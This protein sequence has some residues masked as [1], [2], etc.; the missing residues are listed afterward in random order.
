MIKAVSN[1]FRGIAIATTAALACATAVAQDKKDEK[2]NSEQ[3]HE[4]KVLGRVYDAVTGKQI[5]SATIKAY[6]KNGFQQ[7]GKSSGTTNSAGTYEL[8]LIIGR[9]ST[10]TPDVGRLLFT[11]LGGF[12]TG[13]GTSKD[14]QIDVSKVA[15]VVTAKGYKTFEGSVESRSQNATAFRMEL[16]PVLLMPEGQTG[17]SISEPHFSPYRFIKPS[18]SSNV[19]VKGQTLIFQT[20]VPLL[21]AKTSQE[22][23]VRVYSEI[24]KNG[25]KMTPEGSPD[26]KGIQTFKCS[27]PVTGKEKFKALRIQYGIAKAPLEMPNGK[28]T[29]FF[30]MVGET[31]PPAQAIEA[32]RNALTAF[33]AGKY[34]EACQFLEPYL[35]EK[36]VELFDSRIAGIA[37]FRVN[38]YAKAADAL[39]HQVTYDRFVKEFRQPYYESLFKA[40]MLKELKGYSDQDVELDVEDIR[41]ESSAEMMAYLGLTHLAQKELA[42]ANRFG[43]RVNGLNSN[44]FSPLVREFRAKLEIARYEDPI[45]RKKENLT[46]MQVVYG[47]IELRNFEEAA[48]YLRRMKTDGL[49]E[50]GMTRDMAWIEA[51]TN[52]AKTTADQ[53]RAGVVDGLN[54]KESK[55]QEKNQLFSEMYRTAML[56]TM[57]AEKASDQNSETRKE[58]MKKAVELLRSCLPRGR[59]PILNLDDDFMLDVAMRLPFYFVDPAQTS[60]SGFVSPEANGAFML[61]E[62]LERLMEA[63][64]DHIALLNAAIAFHN[65]GFGEQAEKYL[66]KTEAIRPDYLDTK[67]LRI[68]ID[69]RSG[70]ASSRLLLKQLKESAPNHPII[71]DLE[72]VIPN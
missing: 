53:L 6:T 14:R 25:L 21:N 66:A 33:E 52:L 22:L 58:E 8:S 13:R 28:S 31:E 30:V 23:D 45:T 5:E 69:A 38:N 61:S 4:G 70:K 48:A 63:P 46:A 64:E 7:S 59:N 3:T 43:F 18:V 9:K 20:Q 50:V 15:M 47:L 44:G 65:L 57:I 19:G 39:R 12:L 42:R 56:Q 67:V 71:P 41:K 32:R 68:Q 16:A 27:Y 36:N 29:S 11:Q 60:G 49:N 34:V 51:N 1:G 17:I 62:S 37:Y 24:W 40:G 26:E 2:T 72:K 10:S 55:T 35:A 54:V